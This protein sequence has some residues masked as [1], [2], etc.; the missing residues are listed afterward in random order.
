MK[1]CVMNNDAEVLQVGNLQTENHQG[2]SAAVLGV[3]REDGL[4]WYVQV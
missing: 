4:D 2:E 1:Q 3:A